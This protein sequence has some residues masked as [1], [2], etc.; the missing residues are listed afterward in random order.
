MKA[1]R[2]KDTKPELA[3]RA[4]LH[5]R[6]LRY[7]VNFRPI[8]ARRNTAD[9]VFTKARIA[10]FVDGCYWHGCPD[11]YWPSKSNADYWLPKIEANQARDRRFTAELLGAGWEVIRAW[12]HEDPTMVADR[13]QDAFSTRRNVL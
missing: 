13:I 1:N 11:H 3:L 9:V 8:E 6:G 4:V 10:V 2:S 5:R 7:R 12:E